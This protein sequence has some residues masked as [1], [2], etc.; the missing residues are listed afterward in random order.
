MRHSRFIYNAAAGE[1]GG[2]AGPSLADLDNPDYKLPT[3]AADTATDLEAARVKAA[4]EEAAKQQNKGEGF[5]PDGSIADGYELKDGKAVKKEDPNAKPAPKPGDADFVAPDTDNDEDDEE[6]PEK[7]FSAVDQ[8]TG[9]PVTVEYGDTDPLSPQG[10][11]LRDGVVRDAAVVEFEEFLRTS[12]PR[13]YSYMLHRNSGGSDEEFFAQKALV[14][15]PEV[16]FKS[17]VEMQTAIVKQDLLDKGVPTEVVDATVAKYIK[18]NQLSEKAMV[19]Y[20]GI[21][22]S[23]DRQAQDIERLSKEAQDK[24]NQQV[25]NVHNVIAKSITENELSIVIPEAQKAAFNT[26]VRGNLRYDDGKFFAVSELANNNL[27]EVLESMYFQ[28][29]KGDLKSIVKNEANSL[30]TQRL[31]LRAKQDISGNGKGADISTKRK[32]HIPLGEI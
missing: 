29:V 25:N 6:S 28:F 22:D 1:G 8:I 20:T 31:R 13:A 9:K 15:P 7:F 17:S 14:L 5:N 30:A 32:D 3:P 27:K 2:G 12:D 4:E 26:F 16:E 23:Q 18:D 21:K 19:A 11:A 10:V 24:L